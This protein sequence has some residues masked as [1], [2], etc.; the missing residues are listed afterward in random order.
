MDTAIKTES[1]RAWIELAIRGTAFVVPEGP[2]AEPARSVGSATILRSPAGHVFLLTA[3][4]I[5]EDF[6]RGQ[7]W[8]GYWGCSNA[9]K[10]GI[11]VALVPPDEDVDVAVL[12]LRYKDQRVLETL[13]R[14]STEVSQDA[15]VANG[16]YLAISGYPSTLVHL[17]RALGQGF[18]SLFYN[19]MVDA[20]MNDDVGRLRVAWGK[21][22]EQLF[23]QA[24]PPPPGMSGGALW[25]RRDPTD[26]IWSPAT[27]ISLVGIQSAWIQDRKVAFVEP[28]S[29]W[30]GWYADSVGR[31]DAGEFAAQEAG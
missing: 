8:F 1:E 2:L 4:H 12:L 17:D 23:G 9:V 3:R 25:R 22:D 28:T 13:A 30:F 21:Y 19:C 29:R 18:T 26:L 5:A 7:I 15:T 6:R 11:A 27:A 24:P 20:P 16:D 31:L 10:T 14:S